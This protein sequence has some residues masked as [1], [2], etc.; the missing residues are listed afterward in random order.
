MPAGLEP[1]SFRDPESRVFYAGD[2]VYRALSSDGLADFEA[3]EATHL[4]SDPR[5]IGTERAADTPPLQGLLV[6]EPAGVLRHER[7]P[8]VSYPYEWTFSMLK[9]A[10][11]VQLDLLLAALEHDLVLK[12]SSSACGRA[13]RGWATG[14]S[15]CST[16]TRSCSN[17]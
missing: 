3:V 6:H 10:A 1:G 14:S 5:V 2:A 7:I 12:D 15:A 4:L 16:S 17:R 8:F 11:V 13:S 9:D